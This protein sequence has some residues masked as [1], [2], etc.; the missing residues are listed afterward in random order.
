ML[1]S[2]FGHVRTVL[3]IGAHPD[4]IE[5]GCG[6]TLLRLLEEQPD[7]AVHWIVLSGDETRAA[8]AKA[9]ARA[10]LD[11]A[12]SASIVLETFRDALFPY[13]GEAIKSVLRRI[14]EDVAPDVIFTHRRDDLHQ[15]HRLVAEFTWNVFRDHLIVEYEI[16]KYEGDLGHPNLYVSLDEDVCRRK[17]DMIVGSFRSQASKPWFSADTFWGLLRIRGVECNSPSRFA[18]GLY[19]RKVVL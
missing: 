2:G 14:S 7:V 12:Y 13:D 1:S 5:I 16:P 15:D 9:S 18:E 19:C 11:G 3:C 4:D 10:F 17:V 6:G 8:E